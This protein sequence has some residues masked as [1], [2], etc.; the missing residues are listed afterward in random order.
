MEYSQD[1]VTAYG[2]DNKW[3]VAVIGSN[4]YLFDEVKI[5][6]IAWTGSAYE[7]SEMSPL[8]GGISFDAAQSCDVDGDGINEIL[9]GEYYYGD[10]TRNIW[11]LQEAGDTLLKTAL[12]DLS[13]ATYLNGGRILGGDHGDIDADGNADFVFGSRYSGPPNAM[14]FRVEYDG[15]GAITDPSNWEL[16]FADSAAHESGGMMWNVIDI[17]NVDEDAED[18]VVYTSS[19]SAGSFTAPIIILDNDYTTG[20]R[21]ILEPTSFKLG[22]AYP[23]PFNPS[24]LIPFTLEETGNVTLTVFDVKGSRVATLVQNETMDAGHHNVMFDAADLASGVYVY[25]LQVDNTIRAAKMV[26]NK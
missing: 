1:D 21:D 13:G 3:D 17:C 25:Q 11:L 23:N 10:A 22:K 5:S 20:V 14:I 4:A 12:F 9:T 18:E 26:L 8:P 7:Y 15:D 6:K 2:G 19:V 16:T 24:T